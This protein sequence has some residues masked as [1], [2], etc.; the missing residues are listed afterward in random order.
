MSKAIPLLVVLILSFLPAAFAGEAPK[1]IVGVALGSRIE[2]NRDKLDMDTAAPIWRAE[3]LVKAALRRIKGYESGYVVYGACKAPGRIVRI[4]LNYENDTKEFFDD[5]L[6]ALTNRYGKP[7]EWRGN[8]FGT[9]KVWKWSFKD[10]AMNSISMIIQRYEGED[11]AFTPGNSIKLAV[12][13]YAEEEKACHGEKIKQGKFKPA[14]PV[15]GEKLNFDWYLP[16]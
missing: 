7:S 16:K 13:N 4:K 3:Y 14:D 8:P 1:S 15:G 10:E 9:L 6:S 2:D 11:D 5:L 12:T